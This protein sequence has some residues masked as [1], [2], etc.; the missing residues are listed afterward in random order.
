MSFSGG[1]ARISG[2]DGDLI[3]LSSS[4]TN[5][6]DGYTLADFKLVSTKKGEATTVPV[7]AADQFSTTLTCLACSIPSS[8]FFNVEASNNELIMGI[9]VLAT[10]GQLDNVR[11]VRIEGVT[12]A[13]PEPS[14]WAMM[15]I[16]FLGLGL[17]A[18]RR[19]NAA[20]F[21]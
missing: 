17:T 2:S 14:T 3:L 10:N 13:V 21:A 16:G 6:N 18:Y 20:R 8:G 9:S 7:T 1:R 15:I 5:T 19:N 12:S 11:Q 4:L